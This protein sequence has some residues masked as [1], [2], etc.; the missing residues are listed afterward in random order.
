MLPPILYSLVIVAKGTLS[1]IDAG[2][3]LTMSIAYLWLV[4]K[5]P[6]KDVESTEDLP[7]APCYVLGLAPWAR[8]LSIIGML[9][10][11]GDEHGVVGRE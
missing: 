6:P 3:L 2:V 9:A 11:G 7:T 10:V 1:P 8:N 5:M 4:Q